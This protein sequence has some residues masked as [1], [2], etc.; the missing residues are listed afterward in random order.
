MA[1]VFLFSVTF[2]LRSEIE[3]SAAMFSARV[4]LY[5]FF[6]WF[7]LLLSLLQA[8]PPPCPLVSLALLPDHV[9]SGS[10]V[11]FLSRCFFLLPARRGSFSCYPLLHPL[12]VSD[13]SSTG[14]YHTRFPFSIP[15]QDPQRLFLFFLSSSVVFFLRFPLKTPSD[16]LSGLAA[17]VPS[18]PLLLRGSSI[19]ENFLLT[20][21][22]LRPSIF[23]LFLC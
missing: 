2:G 20:V 10:G 8:T 11:F 13:S 15:V 3:A 16:P 7:W 9:R 6:Q 23:F 22:S 21:S 18:L 12:V 4:G 17:A 5:V 1:F 14:V 19:P